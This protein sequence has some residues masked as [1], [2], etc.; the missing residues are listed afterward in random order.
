M[1][2]RWLNERKRKHISPKKTISE[3]L[4]QRHQ[5][6]SH[7][8][9]LFFSFFKFLFELPFPRADCY[10]VSIAIHLRRL[11]RFDAE[12]RR[13]LAAR[14]VRVDGDVDLSPPR[15]RQQHDQFLRH[16]ISRDQPRV[17]RLLW[18]IEFHSVKWGIKKSYRSWISSQI[19]L[20]NMTRRRA[21]PPAWWKQCSGPDL[22]EFS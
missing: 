22:F 7:Y 8:F 18:S 10:F 15:N 6:L 14:G 3:M 12:Q 2:I 4:N 13:T 11:L 5:S 16:F 21:D 17:E 9:F 20:K 19:N 1:K